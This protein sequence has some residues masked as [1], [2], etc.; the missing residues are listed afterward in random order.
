MSAFGHIPAQFCHRLHG[1]SVRDCM[2]R[3]L[4][5]EM[6]PVQEFR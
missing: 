3:I 5:R 2:C 4:N 6:V 1:G